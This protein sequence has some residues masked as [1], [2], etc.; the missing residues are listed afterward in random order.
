MNFIKL[1]LLLCTGIVLLLLLISRSSSQT[2]APS[3]EPAFAL[4]D[5]PFINGIEQRLTFRGNRRDLPL[6]LFIHGGL[7]TPYSAIGHRFQQNWE[8][9]F[10]VVHWEQPGSGKLY[11][12]SSPER[13]RSDQLV[14][15]TLAVSR[16][17]RQKFPEQA[18][19][20]MG[21]SWGS[22]LAI[23]AVQQAPELFQAYIG[24]G[25]T[26]G[27]LEADRA[28][29]EWVQHQATIRDDKKALQAMTNI[30]NTPYRDIEKAY[31]VKYKLIAQYGGFLAGQS[32]MS[33]MFKAVL[34]SPD[35][36]L[37]DALHYVRGIGYYSHHLL[38]NDKDTVWRLTIRDIR[39]LDIPIYFVAGENDQVTP[40]SLLKSFFNDLHAPKK[41]MIEVSGAAHFPFI[42]QKEQFD[43][44]LLRVLK[45]Q[46]KTKQG[47]AQPG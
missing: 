29:H 38:N 20:I 12:L 17:L 13:I 44:I 15:D 37:W 3:L 27:I 6:L 39:Q 40:P 33:Y 26:T 25:Q 22:Y 14:Q 23:K 11:R 18:L 35:Y 4:E 43:R 10:I 19:Y 47:D 16:Y 36:S 7:G 5:H 34:S 30:G 31:E 32:D 42:D 41:I 46:D 28:S 2:P 45:E 1:T 21:H 9:H 8:Q 24:V